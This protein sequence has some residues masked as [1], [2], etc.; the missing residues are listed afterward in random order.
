ME[1]K[2]LKKSRRLDRKEEEA[3]IGKQLEAAPSR[4]F[5]QELSLLRRETRTLPEQA[6]A[7]VLA[8]T[9]VIPFWHS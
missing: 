2:N 5:K 6:A 3:V 4:L 8:L 9:R 1:F 7:L